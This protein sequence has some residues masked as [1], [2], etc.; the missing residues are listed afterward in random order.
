M[1]KGIM[2]CSA[3]LC[4]VFAGE[5]SGQVHRFDRKDPFLA[6]AFSWFVPGLGQL[7]AGEP[8]RG[9]GFWVTDKALFFGAVFTIADIDVRFERDLGFS[10]SMQ[11][12][13]SP[14]SGRIWAAAGLGVLYL[15]N[16][17]YN[18]VD[19]S[20]EAIRYNMAAS[21]YSSGLLIGPDNRGL[22]GVHYSMRF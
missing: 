17:I 20:N 11:I 5:A 21:Q 7:Y 10:L 15:A 6:A 3:V 22:S 4:L 13:D 12:K 2:L 8:V 18:A 14:S 19:A 16:R 9:A 1:R